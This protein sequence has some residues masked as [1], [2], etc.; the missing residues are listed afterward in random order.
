[1]TADAQRRANRHGILWMVLAMTAFMGNDALVKAVGARVPAAQLIVVRG[2]FAMVLI[3]VVA[4]Q[5]GVLDRA[6][7]LLHRAVLVRAGCEGAA[8]FLYLAALFHLPLA[9][10]TAINLSAPLFV[11][12]LARLVLGEAVHLGRWAAIGL[13]FAGVL[14]VVQPRAEGFN[15][16]AALCVLATLFHASRDLLTRKVPAQVPSLLITWTTAAMVTL[17]SGLWTLATPWKPMP[18][19]AMGQLA[20]AALCLAA[21][22]HLLTLSMRAGDMSVVGP[23]RYS[24]LLVALLLGYLL[25]GDVPNTLAWAGIVLLVAAGLGMLHSERQRARAALD[26]ATD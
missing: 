15:G 26:A 12:L 5:M 21:A 6:R 18:A 22:Y 17:L 24:G 20:G 2:A 9:N 8:T 7:E 13:G 1:V 16:Y 25:W 3:C 19:L 10:V 14:L 23:F 4:R 11:A